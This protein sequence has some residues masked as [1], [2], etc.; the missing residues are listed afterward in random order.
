[1]YA[2]AK[3][4]P[5]GGMVAQVLQAVAIGQQEIERGVFGQGASSAPLDMPCTPGPSVCR[6]AGWLPRYSR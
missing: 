2:R 3:R 1:M 5:F 4:L 6:S